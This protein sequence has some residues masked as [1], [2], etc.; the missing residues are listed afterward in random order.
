MVVG[1]YLWLLCS[2]EETFCCGYAR[3]C[4]W[5][6]LFV[7]WMEIYLPHIRLFVCIPHY[8]CC[9]IFQYDNFPA[10]KGQYDRISIKLNLFLHGQIGAFFVMLPTFFFLRSKFQ[11]YGALY[12]EPMYYIMILESLFFATTKKNNIKRDL[13]MILLKKFH[14][15]IYCSETSNNLDTVWT[16]RV[17][18]GRD[19]VKEFG[20]QEL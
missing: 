9:P 15:T 19:I 11:K 4:R 1:L 3:V 17:K 16:R 18:L 13:E 12:E 8:F 14:K 6:H 7:W 10:Y 20:I 2:G 5:L